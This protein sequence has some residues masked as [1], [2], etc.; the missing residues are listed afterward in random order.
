MTTTVDVATLLKKNDEF[1]ELM[2]S[3]V[4]LDSHSADTAIIHFS[5]L[6]QKWA[7]DNEEELL[8]Y[9]RVKYE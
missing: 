5:E 7:M 2:D 6:I 8:E 3:L 9:R 4:N 1:L